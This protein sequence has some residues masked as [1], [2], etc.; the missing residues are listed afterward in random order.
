LIEATGAPVIRGLSVQGN[1]RRIKRKQGHADSTKQSAP[2][3]Q[4]LTSLPVNDIAILNNI[5]MHQGY[6]NA[7]AEVKAEAVVVSHQSRLRYCTY[8]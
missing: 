7:E 6:Y 8:F 5:D 4:I 3:C 1:E 2:A